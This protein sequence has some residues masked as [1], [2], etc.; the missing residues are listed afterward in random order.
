MGDNWKC[1]KCKKVFKG[2]GAYQRMM[3]HYYKLHHVSKSG[4]NAKPKTRVFK[5]IRRK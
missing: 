3:K 2:K 1:P 4:K 5:P